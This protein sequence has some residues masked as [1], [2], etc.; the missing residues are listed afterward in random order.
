MIDTQNLR[1]NGYHCHDGHNPF[2]DTP[3]GKF[4]FSFRVTNIA[5]KI[6]FYTYILIVITNFL[7]FIILYSLDSPCKLSVEDSLCHKDLSEMIGR[8]ADD[9]LFLQ[10]NVNMNNNN[11]NKVKKE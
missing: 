6:L 10:N 2:I 8:N 4:L 3:P 1:L 11:N 7:F 5:I 9:E